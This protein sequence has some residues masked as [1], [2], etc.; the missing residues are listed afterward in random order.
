MDDQ[1]ADDIGLF[2]R[3]MIPDLL[4]G[5]LRRMGDAEPNLLQ[6]ATLYVLDAGV[7]PTV[8]ELAE[9]LGRS[10]SVSSRMVEQLVTRGW[11]DRTEDRSDR[12]AK[13][14]A[15]TAKGRNFLRGFEGV[16][17]QAQREVMAYLTDDEQRIVTEGMALLGKAS[18]RRLDERSAE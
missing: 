2:R 3:A 12:R 10:T 11:V 13:R 15:I 14:L 4:T 16:R 1:L 9:R 5:M 6:V 18:R 7:S 8:G 17:A